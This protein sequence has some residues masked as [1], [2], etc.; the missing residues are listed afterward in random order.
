[1]LRY[2]LD[3]R[4]EIAAEVRPL[5]AQH[6]DSADVI[7]TV[8]SGSVLVVLTLVGGYVLHHGGSA[9]TGAIF[10]ALLTPV[11][12]RIKA[13]VSGKA[14]GAGHPNVTINVYGNADPSQL[15]EL[16]KALSGMAPNQ[17]AEVLERLP[18]EQRDIAARAARKPTTSPKRPPQ[19]QQPKRRTQGRSTP[20]Q[21]LG[22]RVESKSA[23]K[24]HGPTG[25][26]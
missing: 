13:T 10:T 16:I 20:R 21:E 14:K 4:D 11:T 2:A 9:A 19:K 25:V 24:R 7:V 12:D 17:I 5:V 3:A 15:D 6:L 8:S 18:P 22:R 23:T 26:A 1:M